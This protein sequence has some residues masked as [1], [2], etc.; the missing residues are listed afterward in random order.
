MQIYAPNIAHANEEP[1]MFD[2]LYA[3]AMASGAAI[4]VAVLSFSRKRCAGRTF[5]L[6]S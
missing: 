3:I 1:M 6:G 2:I 5:N 4:V